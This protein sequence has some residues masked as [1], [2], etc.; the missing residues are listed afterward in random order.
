MMGPAQ[1]PLQSPPMTPRF[2]ERVLKTWAVERLTTT[3]GMI[4]KQKWCCMSWLLSP[5]SLPACKDHCQQSK[6]GC[7]NLEGGCHTLDYW[8]CESAA[9][10]PSGGEAQLLH[11]L[12]IQIHSLWKHD[13]SWCSRKNILNHISF[14]LQSLLL[15]NSC[16]VFP[17]KK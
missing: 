14:I 11:H 6:L 15:P 3:N 13:N 16:K 9:C 17:Y 10:H 2:P 4:V 8:F 5:K 1:G 12:I 7:P